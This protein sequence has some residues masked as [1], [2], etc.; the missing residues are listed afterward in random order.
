MNLVFNH[1]SNPGY[2]DGGRGRKGRRVL[3]EV[4]GGKFNARE[5]D[6]VIWGWVW[7]ANKAC[8][9]KWLGWPM[10]KMIIAALPTLDSTWQ[11]LEASV[12]FGV[13]KMANG[14]H[15]GN[16]KSVES[17][18]WKR[19]LGTVCLDGDWTHTPSSGARGLSR[20]EKAEGRWEVREWAAD[21]MVT[22]GSGVQIG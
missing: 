2:G 20:P 4:V 7:A 8:S 22:G 9:W 6:D 19:R 11:R 14:R 13:G 12:C 1:S 17:R 10:R 5:S 3:W 16:G 15:V 18:G 21:R